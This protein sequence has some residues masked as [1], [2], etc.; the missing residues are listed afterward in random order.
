MKRTEAVILV[1]VIR[2]VFTVKV[3][4]GEDPQA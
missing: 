4:W 3:T 1:M 2:E